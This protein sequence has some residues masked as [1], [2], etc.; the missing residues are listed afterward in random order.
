MIKNRNLRG[1]RRARNPSTVLV[2]LDWSRAAERGSHVVNLIAC[3]ARQ[4]TESPQGGLT[5]RQLSCST[6]KKCGRSGKQNDGK[7]GEWRQNSTACRPGNHSNQQSRRTDGGTNTLGL[8]MLIGGDKRIGARRDVG[9]QKIEQRYQ[10][11]F[12]Q[13]FPGRDIALTT[14]YPPP[15]NHENNNYPITTSTKLCK[16]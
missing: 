13:D 16:K 11:H 15:P 12:H 3:N 7:Q 9:D 14:P 6:A 2:E 8:V 1:D 10:R 4:S 5:R